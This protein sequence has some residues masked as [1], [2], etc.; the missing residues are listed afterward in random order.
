MVDESNYGVWLVYIL[1]S[2]RFLSVFNTLRLPR[3][4]S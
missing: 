1:A 4:R 2:L 3:G